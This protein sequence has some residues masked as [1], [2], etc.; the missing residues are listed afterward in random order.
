MK[1]INPKQEKTCLIQRHLY[2]FPQHKTNGQVLQ[3]KM[4]INPFSPFR[5]ANECFSPGTL[6]FLTSVCAALSPIFSCGSRQKPLLPLIKAQK[7][8]N[9]S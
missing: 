2:L 8:L 3:E 5:S 4:D 6:I 1:K 9:F 7:T